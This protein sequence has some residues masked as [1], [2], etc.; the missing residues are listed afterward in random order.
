MR[1]LMLIYA[2][3]ATSPPPQ[4]EMDAIRQAWM[5]YDK[6]IRDAGVAL[7]GEPLQPSSTATTVRVK[8][9]ERVVTD[10]PFAETRE[11]LGGYYLLDAPDLDT[12]LDWA[13][14]TPAAQY[15][16]SLEVRPIMDF[17]RG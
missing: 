16:G 3:E 13:A 7:E 2:E 5:T 6:T 12:A 8:G 15:G 9:G 4:S 1:Y 11:V 14:R 10:G 17:P